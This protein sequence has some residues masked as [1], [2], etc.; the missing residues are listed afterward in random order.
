MDAKLNTLSLGLDQRVVSTDTWSSPG[1]KVGLA[2]APF[3]VPFG[4]HAD[5][6]INR[7]EYMIQIANGLKKHN[8]IAVYGLG[9]TG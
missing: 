3:K 8:R 4:R 1:K 5:D 2:N 7:E 9:G 6:F